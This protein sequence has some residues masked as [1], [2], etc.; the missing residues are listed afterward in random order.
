MKATG[1]VRKV[2]DLGRV[3]IPKEIRKD[4]RILEGSSLEIFID[5]DT[6]C[7]KKYYDPIKI[8]YDI[9]C[10]LISFVAKIKKY[11]LVINDQVIKSSDRS[12][13]VK[14]IIDNCYRND[15]SVYSYKSSRYVYKIISNGDIVGLVIVPQDISDESH[16]KLIDIIRSITTSEDD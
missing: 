15:K 5:D 11:T 10:N 2:D 8:R 16:D 12:T 3:V 13:D 14:E 4:L 6:V 9:L 7:F 1:F